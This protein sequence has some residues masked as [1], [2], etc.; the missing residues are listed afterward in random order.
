MNKH[1]NKNKDFKYL[2]YS[3]LYEGQCSFMIIFCFF[4]EEFGLE[5]VKWLLEFLKSKPHIDFYLYY[6]YAEI[7]DY[8]NY[9]DYNAFIN[10]CQYRGGNL[11]VAKWLLKVKP[12]ILQSFY[13]KTIDVFNN[14]VA[15]W[16]LKK[17]PTLNF[18]TEKF[19]MQKYLYKTNDL[20]FEKHTCFFQ[21][22]PFIYYIKNKNPFNTYNKKQ[23]IAKI[24]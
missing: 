23:Q 24:I 3:S 1:A 8:D 18:S 9:D 22:K 11:K 13:C 5:G 19:E 17:I 16:L 20:K 2:F 7:F 15:K 14:D 6:E 21:V 4:L 12:D 10:A